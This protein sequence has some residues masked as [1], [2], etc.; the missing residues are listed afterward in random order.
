MGHTPQVADTHYLSCTN[1][2]RENATFVGEA[3]PSIYRNGANGRANGKA[4]QCL[5][6]YFG[7]H[8]RQVSLGARLLVKPT[9]LRRLRK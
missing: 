2:M 3:L 4:I 9:Y 1:E 8:L 5:L 6:Q 7:H